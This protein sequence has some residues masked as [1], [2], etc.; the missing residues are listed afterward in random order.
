MHPVG[1]IRRTVRAG[2]GVVLDQ[3]LELE[4][5][6]ATYQFQLTRGPE[7]RVISGNFSLEPSSLDSHHVELPR[8]ANMLA[9]GWVSG[10]CATPAL[11]ASLPL[12]M[13][14]ED[15]HVAASIGHVDAK[16]IAGRG[17]DEPILFSPSWKLH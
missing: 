6:E 1:P 15:C 11:D 10:D 8:M 2:I 4:M 5:P 9:E 13:A 12:R 16:P 17:D 3:E 7:Y 14:S